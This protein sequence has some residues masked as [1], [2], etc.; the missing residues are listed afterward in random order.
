M[1]AARPLVLV[2]D[3]NADVG[4]VLTQFL[5]MGGIGT[6]AAATCREALAVLASRPD[7][8]LVVSDIRLP[9]CSGVD[10]ATRLRR[11]RPALP[12]ILM[13]GL[14]IDDVQAVPSDVVVLQ[15]PVDF[16]E[17]EQRIRHYIG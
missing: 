12:I 6:V 7:I 16:D 13:T 9:D 3:D 8:A 1:H 2:V 5:A 14:P 4:F 10:L 11:D 17:L 15:K